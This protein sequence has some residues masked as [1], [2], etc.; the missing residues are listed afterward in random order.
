MDS[1]TFENQFF[2]NLRQNSINCLNDINNNSKL[3]QECYSETGD[4]KTIKR[5]V[6]EFNEILLNN[7]NDSF[8]LFEQV[9]NHPDFKNILNEFR[10]SDIM[11]RACRL[12]SV[13][14]LE[15]LMTMDIN[16]CVQDE[17]GATA[18]MYAS[19]NPEL[20]HVVRYL[21]NDSSCIN[22]VDSK[23]QNALFYA[24]RN[25]DAFRALVETSININQLNIDNDSVL[26]Y[27]C[28]NKIYDTFRT[29]V[30]SKTL[31]CNIFNN[32]D[33]TAAMYLIQ[34]ENY[35]RLR[36]IINKKMNF[37]YMNKNNETPLSLLFKKH[38]HYYQCGDMEKLLNINNIIKLLIDSEISLN[39]SIDK[40]GNTPLMYFILLED[41]C[42]VV[43][44]LLHS[45][46]T[47]LTLKN[48]HGDSAM[49]LASKFSKKLYLKEISSLFEVD[50]KNLM[51]SFYKKV[52]RNEVYY[53]D[54]HGNN[55][56]MY[57]AFYD[58]KESAA[59]LLDEYYELADQTNHDQETALILCAKLGSRDVAKEILNKRAG[60]INFKDSNG[61]TALHYAVQSGDYYMANL[62]AYN[63]A[64]CNAKNSEGV[65]PLALAMALK[66]ETMVKYLKKPV[67]PRDIEKKEKGSHAHA[68][69]KKKPQ[70]KRVDESAFK[71]YREA[72]ESVMKRTTDYKIN[73]IIKPTLL[74]KNNLKLYFGISTTNA[75]LLDRERYYAGVPNTGNLIHE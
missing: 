51:E 38:Y 67:F 27:C 57:S 65:S 44:I 56:L 41:W 64:N 50:V 24:V 54:S 39:S 53:Q 20:I 7:S 28:K 48:A 10:N 17:E 66:D 36:T 69:F 21:C 6:N 37:Y 70:L 14:V 60:D 52:P 8:S 46:D 33:M 5:F 68:L 16:A 3:I 71:K 40:N 55:L 49:T 45:S 26:T 63:K 12:N 47:D 43:Y 2:T 59:P 32:D 13:K 74:Y 61:N 22:L 9:L 30:I 31:D 4:I 34:E 58:S 29:L 1:T 25:T 75:L 42:S 73:T 18:L 72:Y 11:I 23:R 62:L 19:K 35:Y 15:W